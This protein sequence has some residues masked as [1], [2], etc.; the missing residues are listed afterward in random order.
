M[1]LPSDTAR[2]VRVYVRHDGRSVPPI[3]GTPIEVYGGE[4]LQLVVIRYGEDGPLALRRVP[5]ALAQAGLYVG[6]VVLYMPHGAEFEVWE[7]DA[8]QSQGKDARMS[9]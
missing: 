4:M 2:R 7:E 8:P 6:A 1:S 5:E 3:D 9:Q